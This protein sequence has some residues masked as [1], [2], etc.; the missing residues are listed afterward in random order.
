MV[1][2]QF[3]IAMQQETPHRAAGPFEDKEEELIK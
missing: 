3:P 2:A 1:L